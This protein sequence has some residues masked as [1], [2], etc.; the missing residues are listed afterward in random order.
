M[1]VSFS[2]RRILRAP[3]TR[4]LAEGWK[5]YGPMRKGASPAGCAKSRPSACTRAVMRNGLD[6]RVSPA[7]TPA[8]FARPQQQPRRAEAVF[9]QRPRHGRAI[10]LF[11]PLVDHGKGEQRLPDGGPR[12]GQAAGGGGFAA[13]CARQLRRELVAENAG[14]GNQKGL[15]ARHGKSLVSNK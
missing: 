11:Q 12:F 4:S 3:S 7:R 8:P 14:S 1:S 13:F 15:G 10:F 2:V 6:S 5:S 9:L